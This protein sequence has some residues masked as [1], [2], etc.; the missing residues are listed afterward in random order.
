MRIQRA[1]PRLRAGIVLV[2][3]AVVSMFVALGST[4]LA[5]STYL[6][7]VARATARTAPTL[8]SPAH[9]EQTLS[10]RA[11]A[12][13]ARGLF[14][15][16]EH[17]A[18]PR[19][20]DEDVALQA[21]SA[22]DGAIRLV[23]AFYS[24]QRPERSLVALTSA[25]GGVRLYRSGMSIDG[26]VVAAIGAR[27]VHMTSGAADCELT[28]FDAL[29]S[30]SP[31]RRLPTSDSIVDGTARGQLS[32]EGIAGVSA[33][34][35][36]AGITRVSATEH[37]IERALVDQLLADP[38]SALSRARVAPHTEAGRVVGL[39][40][41]GVSPRGALGL[42]G[43]RNG[44]VLRTLNGFD[45]SRPDAAL[46]AYARLRN[47]DQLTLAVLRSGQPTTLSFEIR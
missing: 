47:A 36:A 30:A 18:A 27:S 2:T 17:R 32:G 38:R 34:Q 44:D 28:M 26:R 45:L 23:G 29:G 21:A 40:L 41:S 15:P 20:E 7:L 10:V 9:D 46:E 33:A 16:P 37:R 14:A 25:A 5:A 24:E 6:P 42:L 3:T 11:R 22:C 4:R 12:V 13:L 31:M 43:L 39:R 1:A 35:L 8:A 19:P